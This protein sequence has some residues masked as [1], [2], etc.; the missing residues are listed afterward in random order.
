MPEEVASLIGLVLR[1]I[2]RSVAGG[3]CLGSHLV[4]ERHSLVAPG[5]VPDARGWGP[6]PGGG[7]CGYPVSE[8][9]QVLVLL[10]SLP[11]GLD[12]LRPAARLSLPLTVSQGAPLLL[13]LPDGLV[14]VAMGLHIRL[15]EVRE[16]LRYLGRGDLL[17]P[18]D[19]DPSDDDAED[20]N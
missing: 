10:H 11:D 20:V 3:D 19:E 12:Q 1:T 9:G 6:L 16:L 7:H 4:S 2:D 15:P 14:V 17:Q 18:E 5:V 13:P 8:R